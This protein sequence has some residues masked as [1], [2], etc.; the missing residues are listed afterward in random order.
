MK[1]NTRVKL[2]ALMSLVFLASMTTFSTPNNEKHTDKN[3]IHITSTPQGDDVTETLKKLLSPPEYNPFNKDDEM[4]VNRGTDTFYLY[5]VSENAASAFERESNMMVEGGAK[6]IT[7]NLHSPGG[8]LFAAYVI[9]EQAHI[10]QE[11]G[12]KIKTVIDDKNA[13][14]SACPII[15][16]LG[17][18]RVASANSVFMFHSPYVQFPY[19]TSED[20][21]REVMREIRTDKDAYAK[22]LEDMC[23]NDPAIKLDIYDHQEH[24]YRAD[25]LAATCGGD[26]IFTKIIPVAEQKSLA[27]TL[28][29]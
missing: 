9:R 19:N 11:R 27:T 15:F 17:D 22:M 21:M 14:M 29:I 3:I 23:P 2:L 4:V 18:E 13:C 1:K 8:E 28:G 12:V 6:E 26:K 7:I 24:Y 25:E 5:S 20:V 16:M 10:L